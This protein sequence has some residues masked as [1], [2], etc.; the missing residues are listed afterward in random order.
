MFAFVR[1]AR[2]RAPS[3]ASVAGM[4]LCLAL[5]FII[6]TVV[7]IRFNG[8]NDKWDQWYAP[9]ETRIGCHSS[10]FCSGVTLENPSRTSSASV[11]LLRNEPQLVPS[12]YNFTITESLVLKSGYYQFWNFYMYPGSN[13]T[14]SSCLTSGSVEY[15]LFKGLA[16]FKNWHYNDGYALDSVLY[17]SVCGRSPNKTLSRPFTAED[18]YYFVLYNP[19]RAD[20]KIQV[21]MTF[22]RTEY[23]PQSGGVVNSCTASPSSKCNMAIPYSTDYTILVEAG[24]PGDGDWG[25]NVEL[26]TDCNPR[27]WV[28]VLIV[29]FPTLAII[30]LVGCIA[31][32]CC[33]IKRNQRYAPLP[34]V[35]MHDVVS[36]AISEDMESANPPPYTPEEILP[37]SYK[38]NPP[39]YTP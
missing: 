32:V 33:C 9:G 37:P 11:Y 10:V 34:S 21:T 39:V 2:V 3:R 36:V 20:A 8:T 13:Y 38:P 27:V 12:R 17:S 26:D 28:Y 7:S 1:W 31:V 5:L 14:F 35:M 29:L 18:E 30:A 16:N 6:I 23:L 4:V 25:T 22:N 15:Y 19:Y 24:P